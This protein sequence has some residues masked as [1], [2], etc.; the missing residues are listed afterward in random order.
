MPNQRSTPKLVDNSVASLQ[1]VINQ[2]FQYIY[3]LQSTLE[4]VSAAN[5]SVGLPVS[6]SIAIVKD[7][8]DPTK[9]MRLE[10]GGL[11][12]N[13]TRVVT[14]PDED[15]TITKNAELVAA[16]SGD[17]TCTASMADVPGMTLTLNK[18]GIW[19]ILTVLSLKLDNSTVGITG[20]LVVNSV[21]QTDQIFALAA[22]G[23]STIA[24]SGTYAQWW[25]YSNTGSNVAKMQ[26]QAGFATGT[27]T[28]FQLGSKMIAI[29][30]HP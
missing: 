23:A 28:L 16:P 12:T 15:V 17:Y 3:Q 2:A 11:T 7:D 14:V 8:V 20:Q 21:A 9:K 5:G 25:K 22:P 24:L 27:R 18:N 29:F 26:A 4:N 10:V 19:F 30:L 1:A 6:D 13:V